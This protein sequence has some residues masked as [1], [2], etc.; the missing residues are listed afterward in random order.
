MV[1]KIFFLD[2]ITFIFDLNSY[3]LLAEINAKSR[4]IDIIINDDYCLCRILLYFRN[5]GK[6]YYL[7]SIKC[8]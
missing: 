2:T 4:V 6:W 5:M 7:Y 1:Y 3:K 8:I